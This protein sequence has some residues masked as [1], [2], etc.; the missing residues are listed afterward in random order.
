MKLTPGGRIW[1]LD[2]S[3]LGSEVLQKSLKIF[4]ETLYFFF[5]I[6]PET[7]YF[8]SPFSQSQSTSQE[9]LEEEQPSGNLW[10]ESQS[11]L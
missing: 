3:L 6:F 4:P 9:Q 5:S 10:P 8:F 2:F 7:L 1:G 11:S